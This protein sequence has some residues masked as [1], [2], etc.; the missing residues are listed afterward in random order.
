MSPNPEDWKEEAYNVAKWRALEAEESERRKQEGKI[1][2]WLRRGPIDAETFTHEH[3]VELRTVV[4]AL[5]REGLELEAPFLAVDA[6]DAISGYTGQLII[7]LVQ[8]AS[9][10][11]TA[12]LVAWLKRPGRRVRVEFHPNGRLKTIEAQTDEQVLSITKALDEEA[13]A[14]APKEEAE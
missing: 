14:R 13:R 6:A 2:I 8:D 9:P 10:F 7:S 5:P 4:D 12:A 3:Q 11:L 1:S